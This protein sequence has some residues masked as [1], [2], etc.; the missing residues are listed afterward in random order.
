VILRI[1]VLR[2][3]LGKIGFGLVSVIGVDLDIFLSGDGI[4]IRILF[5]V[6]R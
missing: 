4:C 3:D 6:R 2:V 5:R 1:L